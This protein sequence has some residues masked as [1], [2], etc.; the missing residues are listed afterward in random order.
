MTTTK[1]STRFQFV[2]R[3]HH[4]TPSRR[5]RAF[6]PLEERLEDRALLATF[7]P[8]GPFPAI[9]A[10]AAP[11][12]IF[13]IE[14]GGSITTAT[15]PSQGPYDSSEDTYVGV[16]NAAN[17]GTTVT[18]LPLFGHS[19]IF[20]FDGDGIQNFGAPSPS[21]FPGGSRSG[22]EG[23]GTSFSNINA[24]G[25][26][27]TVNFND[28]THL[29]LPPGFQT[30][31]SLE[32]APNVISVQ[33]GVSNLG[34][35]LLDP[36]GTSSLLVE[37]NGHVTVTGSAGTAVVNSNAQEAATVVDNGSVTA[38][39]FDVNGG[40]LT[41]ANGVVPSSVNHGGQTPDPLGLALPSPLPAPPVGNTA[42]V[43]HPGT[44]V[45]GL[46]ISG[47]SSVTLAPG[48]YVMEGGGFSVSGGASVTGSGVTIIN[49]PGGPHDDISVSQLGI[50]NLSA[51]TSGPYQGVAVFQDPASADPVSFS[52]LANVSIAGVFYAPMAPVSIAGDAV[53]TINPGAGTTTPSLGAGAMI[54]YDLN[55]R[56]NGVLTINPDKPSGGASSSAIPAGTSSG[57]E[58]FLLELEALLKLRG[59]SIPN[60]PAATDQVAVLIAGIINQFRAL[61]AGPQKT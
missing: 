54:A 7:Q 9:G 10:D 37:G 2:R 59:L 49:A 12:I 58:R 27:G 32:G 61:A 57:A 23:P 35:L 29:G 20:G 13:T 15:N 40:V 43:L 55:V 56:D 22:Y 41:A 34:M 30:Y 48:V 53:V 50:L 1:R 25:T 26:S 6:R 38:G 42:T 52:D 17:S 46:S 47:L 11:S 28:G 19:A 14:P 51:P 39:A 5:G 60:N 16:V 33:V 24:G 4:A 21:G 8:I 44:Y 3:G 45:G 31:F 36:S 18:A